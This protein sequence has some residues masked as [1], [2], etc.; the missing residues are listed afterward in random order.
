MRRH[1]PA[2]LDLGAALSALAAD[3]VEVVVC[4]GG[5]TLNAALVDLGAVDELCLTISPAIVG[6]TS[7]R[8]VTDAGARHDTFTLASLLEADD[9]L[10]GRWVR[11][12]G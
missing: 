10:F 4:E 6:G 3:G 2:A 8:I 11:A 1:G 7:P 5:P 12:D 9:Q